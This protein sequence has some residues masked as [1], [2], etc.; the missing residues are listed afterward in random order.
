VEPAAGS[1]LELVLVVESIAPVAVEATE[2]DARFRAD[3][4]RLILG[5]WE[6]KRGEARTFARGDSAS[7]RMTLRVPASGPYAI[8]ASN[9]VGDIRIIG[10]LVGPLHA[11][12][13]VGDVIA[14]DVDL[15]GNATLRTNVGDAILHARSVVT[16]A[17]SVRSD[18]GD[19][20]AL[21]PSRVD[22][23]YDA[24]ASTDVGEA[25]IRIGDT[26]TFESKASGPGEVEHARSAGFAD[27][28]T[29]VT[30][31]ATT[32]VGDARIVAS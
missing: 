9:D 18:V 26:E 28:P 12:T 4:E 10:L 29:Q 11:R 19:A 31:R 7:V 2:V 14:K 6:S 5:A 17:I 20:E 27:K 1:T 30:V 32:D 25:V 22:V 8:A 15:V 13:D 23:G 3:G 16:G 21:L 24:R